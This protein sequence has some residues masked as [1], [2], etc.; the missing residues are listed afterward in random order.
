M[1]MMEE[2]GLCSET[3]LFSNGE[4]DRGGVVLEPLVSG[5]HVDG[6]KDRGTQIVYE[7]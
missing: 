4:G 3:F 5:D 7:D 1:V 2:Y 6:A